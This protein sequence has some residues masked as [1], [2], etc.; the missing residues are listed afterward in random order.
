MEKMSHQKLNV[1]AAA[2]ADVS[3]STFRLA[4]FAAPCG[5]PKEGNFIVSLTL[6]LPV[7]ALPHRESE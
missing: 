4:Q 5:A 7:L 1:A 2:P 3:D 6:V